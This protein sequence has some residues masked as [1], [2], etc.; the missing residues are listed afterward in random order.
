MKKCNCPSCG[1]ELVSLEPYINGSANFWC[2]N[3]CIDVKIDLPDSAVAAEDTVAVEVREIKAGQL[4][5]HFKG[6]LYRVLAVAEHTESG[7]SLVVYHA[8]SAPGKVWVRPLTMFMSA[9]NRE[10]YPT[11]E[12]N[13]RFELVNE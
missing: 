13:Y 3:C 6:T 4:Y 2:D 7:Q 5:R 10:K 12:Q 1:R 9:V 11:V 8:E